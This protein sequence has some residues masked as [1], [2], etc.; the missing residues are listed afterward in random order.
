MSKS[1]K[2]AFVIHRYGTEIVGGAE[3]QCRSYAETLAKSHDVTVLTSC[4]RNYDTWAN[5]LPSGEEI[6]NGVKV[7]RFPA[8]CQRH[9]NLNRWWDIWQQ[10]QRTLRNEC[11]W[12][13]EQGPVLPD[14]LAFLARENDRFD[15]FIFF[16]YLYYPTVI[17]LP[18]VANKAILV[19]TAPPNESEIWMEQFKN[20][21]RLPQLLIYCTPEERDWVQHVSGTTHVPHV[22]TA[23]GMESID[24]VDSMETRTKYGLNHPYLLFMGRIG[25]NKGCDLLLDYYQTYI[26]ST[27]DPVPLVMAG[28]L[29]M[30]LPQ[31]PGLIY[32]GAIFGSEK[33]ELLTNAL[34]LVN[35]SYLDNLSIVV[36]E[37]WA[38]G[39][40]V[41]ANA[42]SPV[43]K[44]LCH[45]SQGG[46]VWD[47]ATKFSECVTYLSEHPSEAVSMGRSGQSY[48]LSEYGIDRVESTLHAGIEYTIDRAK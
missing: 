39:V 10:Q 16:T 33:Q 6:I 36:C 13:Y 27:P 26:R 47:S 46:L 37:S 14:L 44:A 20:L 48:I 3:S 32:V 4:A 11:Q 23:V 22:I 25:S 29:E 38:A 1:R 41:L 9:P 17:G 43:V 19:P 2:I 7:I 42:K 8:S 5:D 34:A 31:I 45:R 21:L 35:P 28:T 15:V 12:I 18:L 40:P 30:V 24:R